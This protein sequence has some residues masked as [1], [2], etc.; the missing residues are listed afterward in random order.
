MRHPFAAAVAATTLTCVA[1]CAPATGAPRIPDPTA[2]STVTS[3]SPSV[4]GT[5]TATGGSDVLYASYLGGL[6]SD[7]GQVLLR[8][9]GLLELAVITTDGASIA[10]DV[11]HVRVGAGGGEDVAVVGLDASRKPAWVITIGGTGDDEVWSSATDGTGAT[12]LAG[13]TTSKD[14]PTTPR[15]AQRHFGGG[16]SDA[17]LVKVPPSGRQV[18][19]VTYLGG[20]GSEEARESVGVDTAGNAYVSG[21]TASRNFPVTR[22][23]FQTKWAGGDGTL[24]PSGMNKDAFLTKLSPDGSRFVFSTF[25]GGHG[26]E[27]VRGPALD[28]HG[29]LYLAGATTSSDFPV[30]AHAL[31]SKNAGGFADGWAMKLTSGGKRIWSTYLGSADFDTLHGIAT[32]RSGD[33]YVVGM[34]CGS[35]PTTAKAFQKERGGECDDLVAHLRASDGRPVYASFLGGPGNETDDQKVAVSPDGRAL[36]VTTRVMTPDFPVT[37]N[38]LKTGGDPLGDLTLSVISADG[39]HLDYSTYL[40]G[41]GEEDNWGARPVSAP[42]GTV[43]VSGVTW[44]SD[45]PTTADAAQPTAPGGD[46]DGFVFQISLPE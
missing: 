41:T 20:T 33:P 2:L 10:P 11:P 12:Y 40:G 7:G 4:D 32:G 23:A 44:A 24:D 43:Y 9:G 16:S 5:R 29:N 46:G 6:G 37:L 25:I 8:P 38:A 31:Q 14:L 21:N 13:F 34:T 17:F 19:Y 22:G 35:F 30:T 42:D 18:A 36:V 39:S 28:T 1:G 45:L 26:D 15:A 27:G 3:S